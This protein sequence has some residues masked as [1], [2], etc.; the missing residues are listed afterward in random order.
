MQKIS[1]FYIKKEKRKKKG[2]NILAPV[3]AR[4]TMYLK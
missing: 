2:A 1:E 4:V 3:T